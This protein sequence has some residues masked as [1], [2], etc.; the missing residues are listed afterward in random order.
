MPPGQQKAVPAQQRKRAFSL[1]C[2]RRPAES[3]STRRQQN[4]DLRRLPKLV[5]MAQRARPFIIILQ[6]R[7]RRYRDHHRPRLVRTPTAS[8]STAGARQNVFQQISD[9]RTDKWMIAFTIFGRYQ[10][11]APPDQQLR[12]SFA[13][14]HERK[15]QRC[16]SSISA[17]HR[18]SRRV[19]SRLAAICRPQ[20]RLQRL[21]S[22]P[23]IPIEHKAS[24]VV[25]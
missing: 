4:I 21:R 16:G 2:E 22:L 11:H 18:H 12:R 3:A 25:R 8:S 13:Q 19:N 17:Y 6:Q 24:F 15:R 1:D 14:C 7:P 10:K 23:F 5:S 9:C 20:V